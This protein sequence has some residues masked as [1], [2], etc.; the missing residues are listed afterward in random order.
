MSLVLLHDDVARP[1]WVV[2]QDVTDDGAP[3]ARVSVPAERLPDAVRERERGRPRWVWDDTARRYPPL[4]AA[5]V[6]VER[7]H[8][9]RLCHAILRAS[10]R[11]APDG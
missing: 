4:L 6:R 7:A 3:L 2:L 9:L 10:A 11:C 1:G 8:D 5:G